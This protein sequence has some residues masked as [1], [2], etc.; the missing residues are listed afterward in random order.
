MSTPYLSEIRIFTF[1]FPPKGWAFCNGQTLSISQNTALFSLLG[2]TY[3]GDGINNFNL[4]NLQG[5]TPI[6]LGNGFIQG[7][8]G[9]EINH[10]LTQNEMPAHTH[11]PVGSSTAGN[12]SSPANN[13]WASGNSTFDT[14]PPTPPGTAVAMNPA[15]I[16]TVGGGAAHN[17]LQPYLTLNFC[18][19]LTGIFPSRN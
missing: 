17:N 6:H 1:N 16:A 19:A 7:S 14:L 18:I 11:S 12:A 9:G 13:L 8:A 5:S 4:P 10:V 3:G 2:T 15:G